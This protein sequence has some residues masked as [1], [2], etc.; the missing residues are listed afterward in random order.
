MNRK[1]MACAAVGALVGAAGCS[2]AVRSLA[3][4]VANAGEAAPT[5][6]KAAAV[7]NTPH[8]TEVLL[9]LASGTPKDAASAVFRLSP[10]TG[11]TIASDDPRLEVSVERGHVATVTAPK[12]E[13]VHFIATATISHPDGTSFLVRCHVEAGC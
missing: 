10:N 9:S 11:W 2:S 3:V 8:L 5:L 7:P 6:A 4:P 13:R 12:S 1:E